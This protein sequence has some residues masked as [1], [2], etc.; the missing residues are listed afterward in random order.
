[1][2]RFTKKQRE[3]IK[4]E[5]PNPLF[6]CIPIKMKYHIRL[7]VDNYETVA[8]NL[9]DYELKS[10]TECIYEYI[11]KEKFTFMI[12]MKRYYDSVALNV[13][14]DFKKF[15]EKRIHLNPFGFHQKLDI[16]FDYIDDSNFIHYCDDIWCPGGCGTL[17][18]G[19]IDVCRGHCGLAD[20]DSY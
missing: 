1:M 4:I 20:Y 11:Q 13:P 12:E 5:T 3:A 14:A 10:I 9:K 15:N 17:D 16:Q 7:F 19:C 8:E 6:Y 18:C 2:L